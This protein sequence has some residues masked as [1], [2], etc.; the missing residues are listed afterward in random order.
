MVKTAGRA[1]S[2]SGVP[3]QESHESFVFRMRVADGVFESLSVL[4]SVVKVVAFGVPLYFV[5]RI[6]DSFAGRTTIVS[7]SLTAK[8]AVTVAVASLVAL[9]V[10]IAKMRK[11][12][13][14]LVRTRKRIS[15]ME[16]QL[17]PVMHEKES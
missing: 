5:W 16:S 15:E 17:V 1:S 11:Q 8:I 2:K 9:V 6:C 14:E 10:A 4:L 3:S 12:K 7:V 13:N